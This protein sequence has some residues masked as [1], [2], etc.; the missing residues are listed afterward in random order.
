MKVAFTL[1]FLIV[2]VSFA[3]CDISA[4]FG[5]D[6]QKKIDEAIP[7][8]ARKFYNDLTAKDKNIFS[9]IIGRLNEFNHSS[10]ILH[11]LE[12]RSSILYKKAEGMINWYKE[13]YDGL[14]GKAKEF[15]SEI[16][17]TGKRII[18]GGINLQN[19]KLE[20]NNLINVYRR[21]PDYVKGELDNTFPKISA[22]VHNDIL[23][24][25][26][27]S[28]LG[29]GNDDLSNQESNDNDDVIRPTTNNIINPT[30]NSN[31]DDSQK[32]SDIKTTSSP[33]N[34]DKTIPGDDIEEAVVKKEIDLRRY[35]RI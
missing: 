33:D 30:D 19:I 8:E 25:M 35:N 18:G 7:Q 29:I 21:L 9:E 28:L 23:S 5:P 22:L 11:A 20:L 16:I 31:G 2:F 24:T 34:N 27:R 12:G 13:T 26:A 32:K 10:D 15:V 3:S 14:S 1:Y 4:L 17:E 6:I